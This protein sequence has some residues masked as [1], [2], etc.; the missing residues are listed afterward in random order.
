MSDIDKL[1]Q[2]LVYICNVERPSDAV[3]GQRGVIIK[4]IDISAIAEYLIKQGWHNNK[5]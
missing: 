3:I 5:E 4:S 2:D 1:E